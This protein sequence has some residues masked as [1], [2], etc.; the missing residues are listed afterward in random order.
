MWVYGLQRAATVRESLLRMLADGNHD[1]IP[2]ADSTV[3]CD[4]FGLVRRSATERRAFLIAIVGSIPQR[5]AS[6]LWLA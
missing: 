1:G 4:S 6:I 5:P 2:S 3:E